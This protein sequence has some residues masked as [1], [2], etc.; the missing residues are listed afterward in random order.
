M[1]EHALCGPM[2]DP[3]YIAVDLGA[4]SGRVFLAGVAPD[5]L[6]LEETRRFRYPPRE[7]DGHLRW[8]LDLILTEITEGLKAAAARSRDLNRE[9]R[10]VGIDSWA[11]DYGLL[12]LDGKL[13]A[14]PVC[15]RDRRTEGAMERVFE[16]VSREEVFERTGIQ[17]L[18]FNT[19]F[20]LF[21]GRCEL[22]GAERIL[23]LPDLINFFLTG[24]A[25]AEFTN[26]TT[27]QLV[28]ARSGNWDAKLL[29]ALDL[30]SRLFP[31]IV[32]A[33]TDLGDLKPEI[34]E[35]LGLRGTRVIAPATHDTASA[36]AAAPLGEKTAY[37]S[38]GTWS[39]IGREL[40][41]PLINEEV[42]RANFTNEGGAFGTTRFLKNVTGLWIF[43]SCRN[44]WAQAGI[45][46]D[47]ESLI[48]GLDSSGEPGPLVYPDDKRFLN[49]VS[50]LAA[51][52]DQ[53]R[54][55]G[56]PM[57][58][59]P[60]A[61]S[62]MIFESLAF[63]YSS[64]LGQIDELTGSESDS[65]L[66]LGG[67][68]RN[69]YLNQMT[70]NVCGLPVSAGLTEATVLGN[71]LVQAIA[72]G[73]FSTLSEAREHVRKTL[74]LEEYVPQPNARLETARLRYAAMEEK[75]GDQ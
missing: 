24:R 70:A 12:G 43:E 54:E 16:S 23:L 52:A 47:Y 63:R 36:V 25:A 13:T 56:Q 5:E 60:A 55:T 41:A 37:I 6:Y 15:Y 39:L 4:G 2:S 49:P 21:S 40:R 71:V 45:N 9:V 65:V 11:V 46:V 32:P 19:I 14:D 8:D 62:R 34:G 31:E 44:E 29:N 17:F 3:L 28:N 74:E 10:S 38:S 20:Q 22:A 1:I 26:A 57:P 50:M 67:G 68:G 66:I 42:A 64:V 59:G 35:E 33:G 27:T 61:I 51:L 18:P 58:T 73:R 72:N 53:L 75:Y 30:P 7:V 69:R 48:G